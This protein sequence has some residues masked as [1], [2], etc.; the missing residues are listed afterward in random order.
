MKHHFPIVL[1]VKRLK[2]FSQA[3]I[4]VKNPCKMNHTNYRA[5]VYVSVWTAICSLLSYF[6]VTYIPV[7]WVTNNKR[8]QSFKD[9]WNDIPICFGM[10]SFTKMLKC[11][12]THPAF[13]SMVILCSIYLT[14]Q[15]WQLFHLKHSYSKPF[16]IL[17]L[18]NIYI[19]IHICDW[20]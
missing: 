15:S 19:Y 16:H 13:C 7:N 6:V 3:T 4:C 8:K 12:Y 10:L 18:T 9:K 2:Y 11:V 20:I 17:H 1:S 14:Q 5:L